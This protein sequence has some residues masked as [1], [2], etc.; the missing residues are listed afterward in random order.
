[1]LALVS[2]ARWGIIIVFGGFTAVVLFRILTG[3]ISLSGLLTGVL[4]DGTSGFSLGRA[5]LLLF[6]AVSAIYYLVQVVQNPVSTS[7]PDIPPGL[8]L[9]LGGSQSLYLVGKARTLLSNRKNSE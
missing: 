2:L 6:T 9:V 8:L 4:S 3:S 1:M 7:L 5:Q